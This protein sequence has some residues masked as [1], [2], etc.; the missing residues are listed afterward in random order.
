MESFQLKLNNQKPIFHFTKNG[1][2]VN[3]LTLDDK[4]LKTVEAE[5]TSDIKNIEQDINVDLSNDKIAFG[6]YQKQPAPKVT[7]ATE[8]K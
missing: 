2:P 1:E 7:L 4:T 5:L 6:N 3:V 8:D